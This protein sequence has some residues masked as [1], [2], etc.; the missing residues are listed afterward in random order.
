VNRWGTRLHATV[1]RLTRGQL[2]GSLGGQPV[3]LLQTV[4]RRTGLPRMTPVQY[5]D[6]GDAFVVVAANRGAP[7]APAW[8]LNL[9]AD[10]HAH[11]QVRALTIDVVARQATGDER[12]MLW[13]RLTAANRYLE[14]VERKAG[15]ELPIVVLTPVAGRRCR[16]AAPAPAATT[17]RPVSSASPPAPSGIR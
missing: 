8:W 10:A 11:A 2:L 1:Y 12:A 7:R 9:S 17:P 14:R 15:R 3:L 4:G 13:R 5:L 16:C 6:V